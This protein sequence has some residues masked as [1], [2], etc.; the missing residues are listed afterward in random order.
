[1]TSTEEFAP[2]VAQALTDWKNPPKLE[3]L[4]SDLTEATSAHD[5]QVTQIGEWLDNLNVKN[6]ALV[7]TP[8]GNSKIVPKLIRKQA[9]W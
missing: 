2:K 7:N 1:M 9:E 4:K 8:K 6:K 5:A 3:D